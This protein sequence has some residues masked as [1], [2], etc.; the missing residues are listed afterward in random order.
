MARGEFA[1][2]AHLLVRQKLG[3]GGRN[4]E[5]AR[6]EQLENMFGTEGGEMEFGGAPPEHIY[7]AITGRFMPGRRVVGDAEAMEIGVYP[8]YYKDCAD[9][10]PITTRG[11]LN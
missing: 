1:G 9:G 6:S 3:G 7:V 10:V 2:L 5:R 8:G 11:G 4:V